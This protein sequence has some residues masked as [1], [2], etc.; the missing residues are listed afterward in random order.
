MKGRVARIR[1]R[2]TCAR[3]KTSKKMFTSGGT[4]NSQLIEPKRGAC[5]VKIQHESSLSI[6]RPAPFAAARTAMTHAVVLGGSLAGLAAAGVLS[7]FRHY[8]RWDARLAGFVAMGDAVCAFNPVYG[9]GMSSAVMC[10]GIL[11]EALRA[12]GPRP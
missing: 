11:E 2:L 8:E 10:A 7:R 5:P 1:T 6:S 4:E 12:T 3:S 9:Q